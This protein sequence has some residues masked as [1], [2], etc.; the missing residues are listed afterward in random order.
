MLHRRYSA[1]WVENVES[2]YSE[3]VLT[4]ESVLHHVS[5]YIRFGWSSFLEQS[6]FE[7]EDASGGESAAAQEEGSQQE[8][9]AAQEEG[10]QQEAQA[11]QEEGSQQEEGGG[12]PSDGQ[13]R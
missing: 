1:K 3:V 6:L 12:A 5:P 8:A 10:S 13:R 7:G 9:Q 11:A 2:A 4:M